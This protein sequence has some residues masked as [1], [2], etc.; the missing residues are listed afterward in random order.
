MARCLQLVGHVPQLLGGIGVQ[1][2]LDRI[3]KEAPLLTEG[4]VTK[5]FPLTSL[6]KVLQNLLD[7]NVPIRDMRSI[8]DVLAEQAP[9]IQDVTELTTLVRLALGRAMVQQ[10][11]PGDSELQVIGLD[12]QFDRVLSQALGAGRGLEPGLADSLLREA[13]SAME[14]Q[15]QLGLPPVLVVQHPLRVLLAR[16]L[17]RSLP[18][19]TVLSQA[20]IPDKRLI[21]VTCSMGRRAA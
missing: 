14:H 19:L 6:Q 17:R 9:L 10:V 5:T 8:L 16:F 11:F 12:A 20:E 4:L 2:L 3:A 18:Q 1:L 15:G 7:E 21:R 13:A